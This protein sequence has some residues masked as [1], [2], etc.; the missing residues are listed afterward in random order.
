MRFEIKTLVDV[1]ETNARKGQDKKLVNQQDNFNTLYNTIGLR[2]NP[3]EI[4]VSVNEELITKLGFGTSYKGKHKIWTVEF[5][6]EAEAS[7][8]VELMQDDFELVPVISNLDETAKLDKSMFITSA[9]DTLT[10]IIF[11]QIDK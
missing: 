2:T 9:N 3:T 7:T 11:N 8:S 10:N 5:F 4:L 6:V 1:T